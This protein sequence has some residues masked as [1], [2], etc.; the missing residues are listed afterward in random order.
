VDSAHARARH[1]D[2]RG[3]GGYCGLHELD[4]GFVCRKGQ[5]AG[6]LQS[7]AQFTCCT[8][9]KVQ[10]L[11]DKLLEYDTQHGS[12][13]GETRALPAATLVDMLRNLASFALIALAVSAGGGGLIAAARV[14]ASS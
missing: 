14:Y 12:F 10:T 8:G 9:T 7:G 1:S 2:V 11:T 5:A 3:A 13:P 4:Y 6:T